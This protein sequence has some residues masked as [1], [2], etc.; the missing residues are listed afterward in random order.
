MEFTLK[1]ALKSY[2]RQRG[3]RLFAINAT[4]IAA[5]AIPWWYDFSRTEIILCVVGAMLFVVAGHLEMR[6]KTV[7]VRL[8]GMADDIVELRGK[9]SENNL[10]L[11]LIDW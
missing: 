5:I 7:Q 10:M 8:A 1:A 11:E 6:L 4:P 3:W 9:E 2:R